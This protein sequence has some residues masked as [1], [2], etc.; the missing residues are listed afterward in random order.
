[1]RAIV[2]GGRRSRLPAP[3]CARMPAYGQRLAWSRKGWAKRTDRE[4]EP[5]TAIR[6][7]YVSWVKKQCSFFLVRTLSAEGSRTRAAAA[8]GLRPGSDGSAARISAAK[9]A[10]RKRGESA[11]GPAATKAEAGTAPDAVK[12]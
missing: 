7:G 9:S 4:A 8:K 2:V 5:E 1:M 11:E 10:C 3:N 6:R 12:S